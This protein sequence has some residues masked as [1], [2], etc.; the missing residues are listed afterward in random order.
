VSLRA[1]QTLRH[2]SSCADP[3]RKSDALLS[4]S[5]MYS[6]SLNNLLVFASTEA[7]SGS[8]ATQAIRLPAIGMLTPTLRP[9][10]FSTSLAI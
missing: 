5:F 7:R 9:V 4:D 2:I 3:G 1:R 6:G 10:I 8:A